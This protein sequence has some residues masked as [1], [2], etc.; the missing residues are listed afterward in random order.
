MN[1]SALQII[2]D[3]DYIWLIWLKHSCILLYLCDT[4]YSNTCCVS[5]CGIVLSVFV[6]K[7]MLKLPYLNYLKSLTS[8]YLTF[9]RNFWPEET[10]ALQLPGQVVEWLSGIGFTMMKHKMWFSV[11]CVLWHTYVLMITFSIL[12]MVCYSYNACMNTTSYSTGICTNV[13]LWKHS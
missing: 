6:M 8:Q 3:I 12:Y 2:S 1:N 13:L 7:C 10:C 11:I 5:A 4:S 9:L